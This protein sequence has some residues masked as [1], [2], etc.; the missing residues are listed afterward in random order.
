MKKTGK[1]I[2]CPLFIAQ[3]ESSRKI[4]KDVRD[5]SKAQEAVNRGNKTG[6]N[7]L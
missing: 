4:V 1:S 5:D 2:L 6:A 7:A 3:I